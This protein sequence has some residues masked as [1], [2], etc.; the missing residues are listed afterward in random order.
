MPE[1]GV[2]GR[3]SDKNLSTMWMIVDEPFWVVTEVTEE[4]IIVDKTDLNSQLKVD[5]YLR[6]ADSDDVPFTPHQR[7]ASTTLQSALEELIDE[8]T[9]LTG[10]TLPSSP[11]EGQLFY[12][13]DDNI[14]RLYKETTWTTLA[15]SLL[16][17]MTTVSGGAF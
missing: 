10:T 8:N 4:D 5:Y 12:D 3:V 1:F 2:D 11:I 16:N 6:N 15:G 7:I 13:T 17:S 14:F 9:V